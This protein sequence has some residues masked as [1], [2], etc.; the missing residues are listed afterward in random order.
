MA[1]RTKLYA[2]KT[3]RGSVA[4]Q[5]GAEDRLILHCEFEVTTILILSQWDVQIENIILF[6]A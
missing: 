1:D 4:S 6:L 3:M 5:A 2:G